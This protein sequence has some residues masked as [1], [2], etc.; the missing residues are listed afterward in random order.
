MSW[1]HEINKRLGKCI[2]GP[3]PPEY[4][5]RNTKPKAR[6]FEHG[7]PVSKGGKCQRCI[8]VH[9]GHRKPT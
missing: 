6:R 5:K 2:N 9:G 3:I 7:P 4:Y 8:D 1:Q